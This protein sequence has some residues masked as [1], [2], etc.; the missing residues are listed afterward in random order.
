[1][2]EKK[3]PVL[4]V[5]IDA[6]F[7]LGGLGTAFTA[8]CF[9]VGFLLGNK[10]GNGQLPELQRSFQ[11]EK[12]GS[13]P[14]QGR[15]GRHAYV[16][17]FDGFDDLV[18]ISF[19]FEAHFLRVEV[20][21]GVGVV[22]HVETNFRAD[23]CI[24]GCLY[25][26]VEV[27][28]GLFSG[29][30]RK[31]RIVDFIGN[32]TEGEAHR[33]AGFQPDTSRA[34]YLIKGLHVE[35]HIEEI[36]FGPAFGEILGVFCTVIFLHRFLERIIAVFVGREHKGGGDLHIADFG[37][38]DVAVGFYVILDFGTD[39]FGRFQVGRRQAVQ[40]VESLYR[41]FRYGKT[42]WGAG[43]RVFRNCGA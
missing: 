32:E 24:D 23:R 37:A 18:F 20:E 5:G 10:P 42:C 15:T 36:E 1:M 29:T 22:G 2:G 17:P 31:S 11:A 40:V 16:S 35:L 3:V 14:N 34:E 26:F 25:F 13:S 30:F 28:I 4:V 19:V 12:R 7:E 39:V 21:C 27:E 9:R 43:N 33:T 41:G 38:Y 6:D 8:D